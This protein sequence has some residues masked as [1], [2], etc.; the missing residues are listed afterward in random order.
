MIIAQKQKFMNHAPDLGM[1]GDCFRTC[2]AML[3]GRKKETV[4]HF[5]D[6]T[7]D[8]S[9]LDRGR[10]W[11]RSEGLG[12]HSMTYDHNWPVENV[13]THVRLS[14]P[15]VP[16]MVIGY[17]E[18]CNENHAAVAD[19]FTNMLLADPITGRWEPAANV[20]DGPALARDGKPYWWVCVLV[21][22]PQFIKGAS[23]NA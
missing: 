14:S 6:G 22:L 23:K 4:P 1:H 8:D 19:V 5:F 11:L 15:K 13:L 3:M 21:A 7:D 17:L 20:F 2:I 9:G 18:R 10:K 16:F 12:L